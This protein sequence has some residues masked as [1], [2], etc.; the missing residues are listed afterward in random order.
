M[1]FL[2]SSLGQNFRRSVGK[3]K[4]K[5]NGW[6][7]EKETR[8]EKRE[9]GN[10]KRE[11]KTRKKTRNETRETRNKRILFVQRLSGSFEVL[12]INLKMTWATQ[13][14]MLYILYVKIKSHLLKVLH[15]YKNLCKRLHTT[16]IVLYWNRIAVCCANIYVF[17]PICRT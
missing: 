13:M 3:E 12:Y 8:N 4:G 1:I 17:T 14:T 9:T 10:E 16:Y 2:V 6:E 15:V 5:R 7:K 11:T